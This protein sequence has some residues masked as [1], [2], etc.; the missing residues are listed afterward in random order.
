ME[1]HIFGSFIEKFLSTSGTHAQFIRLSDWQKAGNA[2]IN[3]IHNHPPGT[4][5]EGSKNPPPPGQSLCT[6]TSPRD[7]KG[8]QKPHP[9]DI[10]LENSTNVS[11]NSDTI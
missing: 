8:N 11:I 5:L 10:K 1:A 4:R 2:G 7:K 6:K 3:F 9:R